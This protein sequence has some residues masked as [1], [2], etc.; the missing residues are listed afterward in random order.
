MKPSEIQIDTAF[1]GGNACVEKIEGSEV[2]LRQEQ[3]DSSE[4]W[5]YWSFRL[6]GAAGQTLRFHFTD[7]DVIGVR[8]AALSADDG[9]SWQW[10]GEESVSRA[11]AAGGAGGGSETLPSFVCSV[12]P[13]QDQVHL[14]VCPL[15]TERNLEKFLQGPGRALRKETLCLSGQGRTVER[16]HLG[17][18]PHAPYRVLLTARH[19]ACEATASFALEGLLA[20]ALAGDEVGRWLRAN[21]QIVAVPFVHK[22]G[23]ESGDQGKCRAPHDHNRDYGGEPAA[24]RYA[25]VRALRR[26]VPGWLEGGR[27]LALDLHCPWLRG[28]PHEHIYFVGQPDAEAWRRTQR[29]TACLEQRIGGPLPYRRSDD[30][31]FGVDWNVASTFVAMPSANWFC[32]LPGALFGVGLEVP[33]ANARGV[34]VTPQSARDFG[35]DLAVALCHFLQDSP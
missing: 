30:M 34:E 15:Y 13:G 9:E 14:A 18:N 32:G 6:R 19:H 33:Y 26:W 11:P 4:R 31:P 17:D 22:D 23:V 2:W 12:P 5:F 20:A 21:A 28:F 25:E 24:S 10:L 7:G 8:G 3:R 16:L 1:A 29:F 27:G 35:Y